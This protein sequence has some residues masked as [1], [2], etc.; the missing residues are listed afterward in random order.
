MIVY[1]LQNKKEIFAELRDYVY[2][3]DF[4][5]KIN[6][7]NISIFKNPFLIETM[8]TLKVIELD[9]LESF[10]SYINYDHFLIFK[11]NNEYYFCDTDLFTSFGKFSILKMI[12]YHLYLRK[13][14]LNK[15]SQK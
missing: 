6:D 12:D 13:E 1:N 7:V 15:I 3:K 10:S 2:R 5:D 9:D 11:I 14:K 8:K 4:L